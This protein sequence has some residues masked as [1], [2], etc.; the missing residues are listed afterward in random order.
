MITD[1]EQKDLQSLHEMSGGK[2]MELIKDIYFGCDSDLDA[3]IGQLLSMGDDD[4]EEL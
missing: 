3:A 2:D 1:A 4:M